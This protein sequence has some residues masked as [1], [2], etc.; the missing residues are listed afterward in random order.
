MEKLCWCV[1]CVCFMGAMLRLIDVVLLFLWRIWKCMRIEDSC[2]RL[3]LLRILR[4]LLFG[5]GRWLQGR[6][7]VLLVPLLF[8]GLMGHHLHLRR[9]P[10]KLIIFI[11]TCY[12]YICTLKLLFKM[13]G[14]MRKHCC[15]SKYQSM[16]YKLSFMFLF[17]I[18][19]FFSSIFD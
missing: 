7:L 17:S 16:N 5:N 2:F 4:I 8:P 13:E 3:L 18:F 11:S 6:L 1:C 10:S 15:L 19:L 9:F 12:F 14:L